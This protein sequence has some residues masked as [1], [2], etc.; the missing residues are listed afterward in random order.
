MTQ[1]ALHHT[2]K[3]ITNSVLETELVAADPERFHDLQALTLSNISAVD[4]VV[5]IR[6]GLAAATPR[7]RWMIQAGAS[8]GFNRPWDSAAKQDAVN[9]AWTLK[10]LTAVTSL[11]VSVE[12]HKR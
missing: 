3:T 10:C 11:E 7:W 2:E 4:T 6:D 9:T 5:E 1:L 8:F 12:Y